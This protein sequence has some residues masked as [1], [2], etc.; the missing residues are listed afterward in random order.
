MTQFLPWLSLVAVLAS[1]G[2]SALSYVRAGRWKDGEDAARLI[3]R[4][5]EIERD[6]V[7]VKAQMKN[8]ATKADVAR[9]EAKIEG[10]E[11]QNRTIERGVER[12][13]SYLMKDRA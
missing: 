12:I 8:V 9:M 5:G 3:A 11:T 10:V 4:V 1:L 6:V 7:E 2:V 13:E